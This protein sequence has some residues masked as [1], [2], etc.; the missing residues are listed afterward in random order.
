LNV[1]RYL[2]SHP[3]T[4]FAAFLCKIQ[5]RR[6]GITQMRI[7]KLNRLA[8]CVLVSSLGVCFQA[9]GQNGIITTVAGSGPIGFSGDGGLATSASLSFPYGVAADALENLFIADQGNNRIRRVSATGTITTVSGTGTVGF[10]GDGGPATSAEL[11][12]PFGIAV[13]ASG[14]LFIADTSNNRIRKVSASGI[15][16]TVAG[17]GSVGFA[18]DGGPATSAS[19]NQPIGVAVDTSGNLFIADSLNSRIRK[20]SAAGIIATFAGGG[21]AVVGDGGPATSAFLSLPYGVAA[22]AAGNLFI[23]DLL[24]NRIRKVSANGIIT[25][26]AGIGTCCFSSD[27]GPAVSAL[28]G[29]PTGVAVDASGNVF[30]ADRDNNRI[31]EVSVSGIIATV[32]G[33]G[34]AGFSGDGGPATAAELY[35]PSGVAVTPSGNLFIADYVNNRI[36]KVSMP[37]SSG[38]PV[39]IPLPAAVTDV[40]VNPNTNQVYVGGNISNVVQSIVW[41][42]GTTNSIV[43]SLGPGQGA[44]V[45]PATNKIYAADLYGGHILVYNGSDGSLLKTISTF[46]CPIEAVV[47]GSL[48]HIW[49]VGQCGGGNDPAFLIDGNTDT[50]ISGYIGSGGV[51]GSSMAVNPATHAFYMLSGGVEKEVNAATF[52]VTNAPFSAAV[53]ASNLLATSMYGAD[54]SGKN[55]VVINYGTESLVTTLPVSQT[56][57]IAVNP[58]RNRVY[59]V[60]L[61]VSPPVIKVFAGG[62]SLIGS[63][64]LLGSIPLRS[65]DQPCCNMAVNSSSGTIYLPVVN[66][67]SPFLLVIVDTLTNPSGSAPGLTSLSPSTAVAGAGALTLTVNGSGFVSGSVVQWNG[68][69]LTTTLVS[70]TQLTALVPASDIASVAIAQVT[71]TNAGVGTSNA[72]PFTIQASVVSLSIT[73]ITPSS[74]TAGGAAFTLTV[75]GSGFSQ[76]SSTLQGPIPGSVVQ[77]NGSTLPTSYVSGTQVTAPVPAGDLASAGTA[78]VTVFTPPG[79]SSNAVT[80]T[81]QA[82]KTNPAI[83]SVTTAYGGAVIAQNDFIVIKGANLVPGNTPASGTIWSTAP[84]FASGLMP[85]LL[86]GVSVTVNNKPAFVEFFCSAATASVCPQDQLN[87]LTPLDN[88]TGP[89]QVVVTSVGVSSPAFSVNMQAIAPSFLLFSTAGYIAATHANGSLLGSASLYPGSSTPASPKETVV[90]YAV[91][92]GLPATALVNGSATQSGSL[93]VLPVC[94]IGG[95]PATVAFAGLISPGLYQLNLTIPATAPSGDNAVSCTY[96]GATTPSGDLITVQSG[97]SVPT[98]L[99]LL[100]DVTSNQTGTPNNVCT[101]P[102][103][104]TSF[105][106]TAPDVYL[107]FDVNGAAVGDMETTTFYRP[108]GVVYFTN[109]STVVAIGANGYSCFGYEIFIAGYPGASYP[110]VW[111]VGTTWNNAVNPLYS[112]NFNLV[113]SSAPAQQFTLTA[114]TG[115]SGSGSV[116][117]S[118]IG[119]SCGANCWSYAAGTVVTLTATPATGSTFAGWSSACSGTSVTCT[120]TMNGNQT[121]TATFNPPAGASTLAIVPGQVLSGVIDQNNGMASNLVP[122][123]LVATGGNVGPAGYTWTVPPGSLKAYPPAIVIQPVGVVDD[124]SPQSLTSG[125]FTMPVEVSDGTNAVTSQVTIDLSSVCNSSNGN[126]SKPCSSASVPTNVHIS[127]L[128][129]GAIGSAYAASITTEGGTPPYRWTLGGGSLPPG[130]SID[131]A[132]GLLIG[133]PTAAG[134]F[135]FFVLTTDAAGLGTS[136]EIRDGVLAAQFTLVVK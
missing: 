39:A 34:T 65:G 78:Q 110:G 60:D 81:I 25:T 46:G 71:V 32:A 127:Y 43:K 108:D 41:I 58:T 132:K 54:A 40:D 37:A 93:P 118:P 124:V 20:V 92:F 133:T 72:L 62:N 57:A 75:N 18:G 119:A 33:N 125:V 30:I 14:N 135:N 53:V 21:T 36:R 50:L 82:P 129:N 134:T 24:G 38:S 89:V 111:T 2:P 63:N 68:T 115:G 116:S 117:P 97:A 31:R 6:E 8:V 76:S 90:L 80:F 9:N 99:T 130:I 86:G 27:G 70:A 98:L 106:T 3:A 69:N 42:D 13:D 35:E 52:A 5:D 88:T 128:P 114:A 22:D 16:T 61:S 23:A 95:A 12:S 59:A 94:Q 15:I 17:N 136:I 120:V 1:I 47:D 101:L 79:G 91:G 85:T 83:T 4:L 19:L 26:I 74:A 123:F 55:V 51:M 107:F 104:I 100:D 109:T 28:V 56:G 131:P 77:W 87:I 126:S 73:S 66:S 44:R 96:N 10:S 112:R 29:Q 113:S 48:N 103:S 105:Q 102:P 7:R 84:S 11:N 122:Y 49:G 121:V 45:N 67:G 64:T